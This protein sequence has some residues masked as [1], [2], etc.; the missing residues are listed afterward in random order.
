MVSFFMQ[1]KKKNI[2]LAV[3]FI[4]A[5]AVVLKLIFGGSTLDEYKK[6]AD[7]KLEPAMEKTVNYVLKCIEKDDMRALFK[8][9]FSSDYG[10][11]TSNYTKG[12]F[13][14]K[15]FMPAKLTGKVRTVSKSSTRNVM[16]EVYSEKRKCNYFISLVEYK[17]EWKVAAIGNF[18]L[19][20]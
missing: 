18:K 2:L 20:K 5:L 19:P 11:F 12:L 7:T 3:L 17:N 16:V 13:A 15:D 8:V 1:N 14:Q 9:M 10:L 6:T 4:A